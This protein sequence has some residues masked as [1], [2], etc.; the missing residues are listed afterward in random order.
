MATAQDARTP[1]P[2]PTRTRELWRLAAAGDRDAERRLFASLEHFLIHEAARHPL[3]RRLRRIATPEDVAHEVW[4]RC[5]ESRALQSFEDRGEGSL[6]SFLAVILSRT[7]HDMLRRAGRRKRREELRALSLNVPAEEQEAA[8]L[9]AGGTTP[10]GKARRQEVIELARGCLSA[11]EWR[12]WQAI[13]IEGH[14][15]EEVGRQLGISAS[16]ARSMLHRAR[17]K[18]IARVG[19]DYV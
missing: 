7:I 13:E 2:D 17:Q 4:Q 19:A 1:E 5:F 12:V 16:A 8:E 6:R 18:L 3:M 14:A 10:T 9:P 11:S 15:A